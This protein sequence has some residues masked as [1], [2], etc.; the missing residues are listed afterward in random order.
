F[1]GKTALRA[2]RPSRQLAGLLLLDPGGVLRA[3]HT[4]HGAHGGGEV[5]SGTY[6]P[7]LARS[8]ALARLPAAAVPGDVVEVDV[9]GKS[10]SARVVKPPFVRHGKSL[11]S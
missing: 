2:A 10:L 11:V 1:V 7:T 6:S 5:T 3:H 4:V 8:I 9:R